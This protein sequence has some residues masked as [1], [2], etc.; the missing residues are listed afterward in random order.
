ME[1]LTIAASIIGV[2]QLTGTCLKLCNRFLGPSKHSL[3]EISATL[4]GFHGAIRNLQTHLEI[5]EEDQTRLDALNYLDRP[6]ANCKEA[7][8]LL[9]KRLKNT[10]FLGQYVVGNLF[11]KRLKGVLDTL[12]NS[13]SVFELTLHADQQ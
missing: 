7:L 9:E 13:K 5:N 3:E 4:Y 2:V 1:V 11:D 8:E 6:L 10:S 12:K